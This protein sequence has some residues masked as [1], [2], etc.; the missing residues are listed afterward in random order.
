MCS[1]LWHILLLFIFYHF[2]F[3]FVIFSFEATAVYH[4]HTV[5]E[6]A[7]GLR[8]TIYQSEICQL[9]HNSVGTSCTTNLERIE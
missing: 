8:N 4:Y 5:G 7:D 9:L 3:L 6:Q 1:L 2:V